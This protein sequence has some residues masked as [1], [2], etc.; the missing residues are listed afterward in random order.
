MPD[1]RKPGTRQ[2]AGLSVSF[3]RLK[4]FSM[5]AQFYGKPASTFPNCA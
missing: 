4:A 3:E 2:R 1:A 5:G